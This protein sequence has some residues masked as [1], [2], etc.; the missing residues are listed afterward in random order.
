MSLRQ[1]SQAQQRCKK[2]RSLPF[3]RELRVAATRGSVLL[4]FTRE[5]RVSQLRVLCSSCSYAA[6]ASLRVVSTRVLLRSSDVLLRGATRSAKSGPD[7][8]V[9]DACQALL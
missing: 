2:Q 7:L 1:V 3:E 5:L 8:R 4:S 9:R 6:V